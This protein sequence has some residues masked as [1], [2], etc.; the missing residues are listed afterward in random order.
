MDTNNDWQLTAWGW[1][2]CCIIFCTVCCITRLQYYNFSAAA[3]ISASKSSS[4]IRC[5]LDVSPLISSA[6]FLLNEIYKITIKFYKIETFNFIAYHSLI[7]SFNISSRTSFNTDKIAKHSSIFPP[8]LKIRWAL[9]DKMTE[10]I[11]IIGELTPNF[12]QP[13]MLFRSFCDNFAL[14]IWMSLDF[15]SFFCCWVEP[16]KKKKKSSTCLNHSNQSPLR[17]F[18]VKIPILLAYF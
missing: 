6:S 13:C 1:N 15:F 2:T 11:I 8:N 18:F 3:S 10:A 17:W 4:R 9:W 14:W 12:W 7:N 16:L 5:S